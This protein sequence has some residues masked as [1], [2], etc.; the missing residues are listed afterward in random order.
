MNPEHLHDGT[1]ERKRIGRERFIDAWRTTLREGENIDRAPEERLPRTILIADGDSIQNQQIDIINEGERGVVV[2]FKLVK[3]KWK[4]LNK[5]LKKEFGAKQ[6]P[7]V[8]YGYGGYSKSHK[9]CS[10]LKVK[11]GEITMHVAD[12]M[13]VRSSIGLVRIEIPNDHIKKEDAFSKEEI[14]ALGDKLEGIMKLVL[15]KDDGLLSPDSRAEKEYKNK[16]YLWSHKYPKGFKPTFEQEKEIVSSLK[17]EEVAP[18][19]YTFVESGRSKKMEEIAPF[20]LSHSIYGDDSLSKMI[21]A[22]AILSSHERYRRGLLVHGSSTPADL[23]VGGGD[24]VFLR[25]CA[26][27]ENGVSL[28]GSF[29]LFQHSTLIFDNSILDRTDSYCYRSDTFGATNEGNFLGRVTP[30]ELLYTQIIN[31]SLNSNE[32][33]FQHGIFFDKVREVVVYSEA[34]KQSMIENLMS[35][36]IFKVNGKSLDDFIKV[37]S[38]WQEIL[39]AEPNYYERQKSAAKKAKRAKIELTKERLRPGQKVTMLLNGSR[40]EPVT[41]DKIDENDM[42]SLIN[43]K[44]PSSKI[45]NIFFDCDPINIGDKV[46]AKDTTNGLDAGK[47]YK[48]KELFLDRSG[49]ISVNV[50]L[51]NH[52]TNAQFS[53]YNF[54]KIPPRRWMSMARIF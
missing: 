5:R 11:L 20:L 21:K 38:S 31:G 12:D 22:G 14:E 35:N 13:E 49:E 3:D 6:E 29:S 42:V 27:K 9:L 37:H 47:T 7:I 45:E 43:S 10:G 53:V 39:S 51:P 23:R 2:T 46:I 24:G 36:N 32:I 40:L 26:D 4:D 18:G 34:H 28:S 16:R 52:D 8:Y 1:D 15:G 44:T 50:Y 41:I 19:Y 30:E 33:I 54:K 17:R 25:M 48:I